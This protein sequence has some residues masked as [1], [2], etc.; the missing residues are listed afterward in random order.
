MITIFTY[1]P[2]YAK[3]NQLNFS[4][5]TD[6]YSEEVLQRIECV[7]AALGSGATLV[8]SS[9][10]VRFFSSFAVHFNLEKR[11]AGLL[12]PSPPAAFWQAYAF[13]TL[14]LTASQFLDSEEE[15]MDSHLGTKLVPGGGVDNGL[16]VGGAKRWIHPRGSVLLH[17]KNESGATV[18]VRWQVTSYNKTSSAIAEFSEDL[19][20]NSWG[21]LRF[22]LSDA[23]A[24]TDMYKVKIAARVD[25]VLRGEM[26]FYL[27]PNSKIFKEIYFINDN[28]VWESYHF[29]GG[30]SVAVN[31][32]LA[33]FEYIG[34]FGN[35]L[36]RSF[37]YYEYTTPLARGEA[38]RLA[39]L[40]LQSK[41]YYERTETGELVELF[42]TSST[43][44]I[45]DT[46][47]EVFYLKFSY[48]YAKVQD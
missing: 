16:L 29:I 31:R 38:E 18:N 32:Q 20:A 34:S 22:R 44:Q 47:N 9:N 1:P 12:P 21:S 25:W 41:K 2:A 8:R 46:D 27:Y 7:M 24:L 13:L 43:V 26:S 23:I 33:N 28:A 42:I 11:V 5:A 17:V 14:N 15:S 10:F 6:A 35:S 36:Q 30:Q 19:A 48:R 4:I 37:L 40:F 45:S 3:A 39:T